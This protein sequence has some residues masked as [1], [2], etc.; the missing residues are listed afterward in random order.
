LAKPSAWKKAV[1]GALPALS[2]AL[3]R[4]AEFI[5]DNPNEAAL[6]PLRVLAARVGSPPSAFTRF[7]KA[8]GYSGFRPLQLAL[9][10]DVFV[11]SKDL[12]AQLT[13]RRTSLVHGGLSAEMANAITGRAMEVEALA[14]SLG[15][16]S[17]VTAA[18]LIAGS[19]GLILAHDEPG[20]VPAS[21]LAKLLGDLGFI[22][23]LRS[24]SEPLPPIR[25][26]LIAFLLS[27]P[28]HAESSIE[29]HLKASDRA[30]LFSCRGREDLDVP[31]IVSLPPSVASR[32]EPII[33]AIIAAEI[34]AARVAFL[35]RPRQR[36]EVDFDP[37]GW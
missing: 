35:R 22:V 9:K 8:V 15:N 37:M 27:P 31:A 3:R 5:L 6:A 34:L 23:G 25:I 2:P 36:P 17:I 11:R 10:S 12:H 4:V 29:R 20:W 21:F 26:P 19:D 1:R 16:N 14:E 33:T 32:G 28:T 24:A 7:A 13:E 30:I 18:N